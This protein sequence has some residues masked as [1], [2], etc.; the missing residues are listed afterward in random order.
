ML[1]SIE[2]KME[3]DEKYL[4]EKFPK[5]KTKF[6]REAMVLLA[7]ARKEGRKEINIAKILHEWYE[8]SRT[9]SGKPHCD[10]E[11]CD[12]CFTCFKELCNK[13]GLDYVCGEVIKN[14]K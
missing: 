12:L 2:N 11:E 13:F 7:L 4:D 9:C 5:G 3:E 8:D 1:I 14:G 10:V 6:R